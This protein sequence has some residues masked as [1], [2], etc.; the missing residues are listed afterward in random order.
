MARIDLATFGMKPLETHAS[1]LDAL[2]KPDPKAAPIYEIMS[3]ALVW[4]DERHP[5]L[6]TELIYSLRQLWHFRTL[7]I[8]RNERIENEV[9]ARCLELFPNWIGFYQSV[10]YQ[11]RQPWP[12]IG[13]GRIASLV[14]T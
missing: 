13:A 7:C 1:V 9:V 12:S 4:S 11:L 6:T 5:S 2:C 8:L 14:F 3:D 10:G